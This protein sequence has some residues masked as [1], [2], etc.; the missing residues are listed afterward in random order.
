MVCACRAPSVDGRDVLTDRAAVIE[1]MPALI[2][3]RSPLVSASLANAAK[4]TNS[5]PEFAGGLEIAWNGWP[6]S[7][8]NRMPPGMTCG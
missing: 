8:T 4:V 7:S 3:T 5:P 6:L 1:A 2:V